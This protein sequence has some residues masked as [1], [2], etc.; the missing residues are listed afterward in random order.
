VPVVVTEH[1]VDGRIRS[2][3]QDAGALVSLSTRG[4]ELL[5]GRWPGKRVERIAHGCPTW[6]PPRK[7]RRGRVIGVLGFLERHKGFWHLLEVLRRVPGTELL[8][9]SYAKSRVVEQEWEE[10][11]GGLPVRR[12]SAYL[13][14]AEIARQ[15]AA[16]ADVLAFPYDQ[17]DHVSVSGAVRIGLASGVPVLC[18][19]T[20]W[21]EDLKEITYQPA[22]LTDGLVRLM[23]DSKM[24]ENL[25]Q[26]SRDYC[27]ENSWSRIAEKHLSLWRSLATT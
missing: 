22:D 27:Y 5:R 21:F 3:E 16:E 12:V 19:S 24:R 23:E 1:S 11:S 9:F 6:F 7:Q 8:M 20:R 18:S 13:P 4:A 25:T 10:A 2:W 26:A 17:V 14:E 15:L